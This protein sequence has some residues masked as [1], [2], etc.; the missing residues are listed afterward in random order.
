MFEFRTHT[1]N[2]CDENWEDVYET[3]SKDIKKNRIYGYGVYKNKNGHVKNVCLI[4]DDFNPWMYVEVPNDMK[5]WT[6]S[7][8]Q[9]EIQRLIKNR[10]Y[11]YTE[12]IVSMKFVFMKK[13]FYANLNSDYTEKTFPYIKIECFSN[14]SRRMIAGNLRK[15]FPTK[16]FESSYGSIG[17]KVH[18]TDASPLLQF[19]ST[20]QINIGGWNMI[21]GSKGKQ[22]FIVDTDYKISASDYEIK[23]SYK[24]ITGIDK[25]E[26]IQPVVLSFDIECYSSVSNR[27]P[28]ASYADDCAFQIG[29]VVVDENLNK[30]KYLLCFSKSGEKPKKFSSDVKII[31]FKSEESMILGFTDF[32]HEQKINII[33]GWNIMG[34]DI[35]YLYKRMLKFYYNSVNQFLHQ[36]VLLD[37][38][39]EYKKIAW[40]STAVR[41]RSYKFIDTNGRIYIDMMNEVMRN[42]SYKFDSYSL[43]FVSH[44]FLG[45]TKD[46]LSAKQMFKLFQNG[47]PTSLAIIGKYC[48]Q[49][50][51]LVARIF[52]K[53]KAWHQIS[54]MSTV[55]R[56][57]PIDLG[58]RG[59]QL[60]V[61]SQIYDYC[62]N[63]N[64]VVEKDAYTVSEGEAYGGAYVFPPV[65]G[66]YENVL[67]FDFASLYP[68]IIIA[69]NICFSTLVTDD[70][71][72]DD[73]C[74]IFDWIEHNGCEHDTTIRKSK[75]TGSII[76]GHFK[77]RFLKTP[78]GVMPSKLVKLIAERKEVRKKMKPLEAKLDD[79]KHN[80]IVVSEKEKFDLETDLTV[81]D[82]Q[83]L[84]LKVSCNSMYGAMGVKKGFLPFMPGAMCTTSRGR[85]S[86]HF[87]SKILK[88]KFGGTIVYGDTDSNYV[89]FPHLTKPEEIWDYAL[90][91]QEGLKEYFPPPMGMEFENVNYRK[92]L[93]FGKKSYIMI[94]CGRDGIMSDKVKKRGVMSV[95]RGNC[96]YSRKL[97][98]DVVFKTLMGEIN[99]DDILYYSIQKIL[100]ICQR[101]VS[102]EDLIVTASLGN[103]ENYKQKK[104]NEDPT[105]RAAQLKRKKVTNEQDFQQKSLPGHVQLALKMKS[106]GEIVDSGCR[107]PYIV[108]FSDNLKSEKYERL[109]DPNYFIKHRT[110]FRIDYLSYVKTLMNA[111]DDISVVAWKKGIIFEKLY[112]QM[113]YKQKVNCQIKHYARRNIVVVL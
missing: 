16:G 74:N 12:Q 8:N 103:I 101:Q 106:R 93:I 5:D 37:R 54:V 77:F 99:F 36:G 92:Y 34:F 40:S 111:F 112:K 113:T 105:K 71:V 90:K 2:C 38:P 64:R 59:Q 89:N 87:A 30:K 52:D 67:P 29:C 50:S 17:F 84:A 4:I 9:T 47:D 46:D 25:N 108:L 98:D 35:K 100:A 28:K 24:N 80:K 18:E 19:V 55:C 48:V 63:D 66:L 42:P 96:K 21:N 110:I 45:D 86:V 33:T 60:K 95:R 7:Q 20:K 13:L 70:S 68:S 27:M 61:Y 43:N 32:L 109:E 88:E 85:E 3:S 57:P 91:V 102:L 1:W 51:D 39:C 23:S 73:L 6:K 10:L 62:V 31:D 58:T 75:K 97:Y 15:S 44:E 65:P 56:V 72:P 83:Q 107:I 78:M 82:A 26:W 76:C 69:Y 53:L 104:L 11:K 94:P 41:A 79:I 49:D 22:Y 81:L 14:E